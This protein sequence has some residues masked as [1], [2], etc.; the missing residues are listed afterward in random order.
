M[1]N[2][3]LFGL[4]YT[5]IIMITNPTYAGERERILLLDPVS[6]TLKQSNHILP[7]D[8]RVL[9]L[10]IQTRSNST[11]LALLSNK[12]NSQ[13]NTFVSQECLDADYSVD[14]NTV[15]LTC[16]ERVG[17]RH[18][19]RNNTYQV[20]F[21]I[22]PDTSINTELKLIRSDDMPIIGLTLE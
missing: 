6:K 4:V 16:I 1:R 18:S 14:G 21:N 17:P 2:S 7:D 20:S 5:L 19:V 9:A 22:Q 8:T 10:L 11:V 3:C 15:S 13:L 12:P